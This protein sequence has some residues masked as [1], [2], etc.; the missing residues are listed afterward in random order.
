M[1]IV[2]V[3]VVLLPFMDNVIYYSFHSV[4][5]IRLIYALIGLIDKMHSILINIPS[6]ILIIVVYDATP[7]HISIMLTFHVVV[8]VL[9][10]GVSPKDGVSWMRIYM[11]VGLWRMQPKMK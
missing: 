7:I 11:A 2:V 3:I 6:I 5:A 8:V 9:D 10:D 1:S 4:Q